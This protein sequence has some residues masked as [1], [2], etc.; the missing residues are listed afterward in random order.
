MVTKKILENKEKIELVMYVWDD[1]KVP[2]K[3]DGKMVVDTIKRK[4]ALP[5]S[6]INDCKLKVIINAGH[7]KD[8][9][10]DVLFKEGIKP[11][12]VTFYEN[13]RHDNIYN[14]GN[15]ELRKLVFTLNILHTDSEGKELMNK[16]VKISDAIYVFE[17]QV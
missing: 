8:V 11:V 12:A 2:I 1:Y 4:T 6:E 17:G 14:L 9:D 7:I 13:G 3:K 15:D 5:V 16:Q 10:D